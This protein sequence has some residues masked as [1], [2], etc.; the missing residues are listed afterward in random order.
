MTRPADWPERLDAELRAA[1]ARPFCWATHDCFRFAARVVRALGGPDLMAACRGA[2]HDEASAEAAIGAWGPDLDAGLV[3]LCARLGMQ[4]I[5]PAFAQRG[6]LV[7]LRTP[8]GPTCAICAG[9]TAAAAAEAGGVLHLPMSI[10][11]RAWAV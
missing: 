10:A 1:A 9:R 7:V 6:D 3:A 8:R 11:L 5:P 2:W 4:Q